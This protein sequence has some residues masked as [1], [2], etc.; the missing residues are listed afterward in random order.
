LDRA[1]GTRNM[2]GM[3]SF[4]PSVGILL[5]WTDELTAQR[6]GLTEFQSLGR[7]SVGLDLIVDY[8]QSLSDCGFNPSVGILLVW[9]ADIHPGTA[10]ETSFNPSVGILLVWTDTAAKAGN[11]FIQV[12]I[13]RS[14]FC[15]FGP[16]RR[17]GNHP[18]RA[19]FNPSVGI[20]LVWTRCHAI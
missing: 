12:S 6:D 7:D 18:S 8:R 5:V 20:L 1:A 3:E 10:I 4:N 2:G 14:G 16:G 17:W 19:C 11:S 13:P 9:T 15:W